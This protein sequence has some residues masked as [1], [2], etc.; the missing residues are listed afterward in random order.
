MRESQIETRLTRLVQDQGGL[1]WKFVSPGT[2]GVPDRIVV[3]A[4]GRVFFVELKTAAGRLSSV[5]RY[6]QRELERRGA[7]VRTLYGPEQVRQF[8][9]EVTP[10][11]V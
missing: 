7:Q 1:C 3:T 5:Q 6:R 2:V 9:A 8:I 11:E 10:D 4:D